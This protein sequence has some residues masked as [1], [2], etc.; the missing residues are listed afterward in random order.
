MDIKTFQDFKEGLSGLVKRLNVERGITDK[1]F[2]RE[3][4]L[5]INEKSA[6]IVYRKY[7]IA[8]I[9]EKWGVINSHIVTA[10]ANNKQIQKV[11]GFLHDFSHSRSLEF[12]TFY[13]CFGPGNERPLLEDEI[14]RELYKQYPTIKEQCCKS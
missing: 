13:G 4:Q 14:F 8:D 10:L 7:I 9:R 2:R 3:Y 6:C 5:N 12:E 1:I 11:I